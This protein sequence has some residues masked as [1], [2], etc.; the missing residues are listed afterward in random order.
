LLATALRY[1]NEVRDEKEYFDDIE[2]IKVPA[3]MLK[4]ATHILDTKKGHFK[5]EKFEDRY[6][7]ALIELIKAK[8]AGKEPPTLAEPK[9]SNVVNLMDALRRSAQADRR[10]PASRAS[11]RKNGSHRKRSTARRKVRKAS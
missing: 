6:E 10:R 9:P 5:P 1:A 2:N 11:T 3:D 7:N 8:R 4:L